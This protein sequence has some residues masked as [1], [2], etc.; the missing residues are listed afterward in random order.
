MPSTVGAMTDHLL[1]QTVAQEQARLAAYY[2]R[3]QVRDEHLT[4]AARLVADGSLPF[5]EALNDVVSRYLQAGGD[6]DRLQD[7][8]ERLGKRL[9]DLAFRFEQGLENAPLAVQRP[10]MHPAVALGLGIDPGGMLN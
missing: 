7:A 1:N 10:D 4:E 3:G 5:Y 8:E 2:G 6:I 9:S